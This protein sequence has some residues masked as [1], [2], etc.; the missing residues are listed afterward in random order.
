MSE[1]NEFGLKSEPF[2][3]TQ[4]KISDLVIKCKEIFSFLEDN[5]PELG[6]LLSSAVSQ[7]SSSSSYL[8]GWNLRDVIYWIDITVCE[9]L[10]RDNNHRRE[11]A[12]AF[13]ILK[14]EVGSAVDTINKIPEVYRQYSKIEDFVDECV[15]P[16]NSLYNDFLSER[17]VIGV[18]T[19]YVMNCDGC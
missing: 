17:P 4:V 18:T 15:T 2:A 9:D 1:L 10:E 11:E 7:M 14:E 6:D 12:E 3:K 8:S 19:E 5:N 16:I 13:D